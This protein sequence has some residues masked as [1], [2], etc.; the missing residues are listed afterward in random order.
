MEQEQR[1]YNKAV[2]ELVHNLRKVKSQLLILRSA[3]LTNEEQQKLLKAIET[4][5]AEFEI[6]MI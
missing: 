3:Q 4:V 1:I 2:I 5:Q 6:F